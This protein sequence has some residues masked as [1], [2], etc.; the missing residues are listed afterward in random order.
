MQKRGDITNRC[1]CPPEGC[2][3]PR[4]KFQNCKC[5]VS[6]GA[7]TELYVMHPEQRLIPALQMSKLTP[8]LESCGLAVPAGMAITGL[9]AKL[10]RERGEH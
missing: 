6:V 2:L 8:G 4:P 9:S 1:S 7:A 5:V 10:S 3:E